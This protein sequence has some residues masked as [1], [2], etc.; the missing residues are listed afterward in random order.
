ADIQRRTNPFVHA[1]FFNSH[2]GA[3]DVHDG[4]NGPNFVKMDL[5][6]SGVVDPGFR[7]AQRFKNFDG[8][9]FCALADTRLRNDLANF[10]QPAMAVAVAG[11]VAVL[12]LVLVRMR[13]AMRVRMR[14]VM[15]VRVSVRAFMAT[16]MRMHSLL[17]PEFFS[18]QV[19][20]PAVDDI[21]LGG[22]DSAPVHAPDLK[23]RIQP[24]S[25]NGPHKDL[26]RNSGVHQRAQ[27]H[28]AADPGKAL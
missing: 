24:K 23:M 22:A 6:N 19:L 17:S 18:R 7:R 1:E 4:V 2:R 8:A 9:A 3:Y 10:F 16:G 13:I 26:G 20:F 15:L 27:K 21:H 14:V 25:I 12:M 5:L 11:S 28:I